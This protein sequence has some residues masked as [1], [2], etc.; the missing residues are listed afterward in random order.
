M[1]LTMNTCKFGM[2]EP[3]MTLNGSTVKLASWSGAVSLSQQL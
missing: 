1:I 2:G 3:G